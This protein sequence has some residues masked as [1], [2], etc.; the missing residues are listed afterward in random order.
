M[1]SPPEHTLIKHW[2]DIEEMWAY[3]ILSPCEKFIS[4]RDIYSLESVKIAKE[5][6]SFE[7]LH[8]S[9][10]AS[11]QMGLVLLKGHINDLTNPKHLKEHLP[12]EFL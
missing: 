5:L 4:R 8:K 7:H 9:Y 6:M 1:I 2:C 11:I 3:S 10:I 12:E